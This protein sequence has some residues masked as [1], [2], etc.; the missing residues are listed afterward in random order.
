MVVLP[1]VDQ[2]DDQPHST[3]RLFELSSPYIYFFSKMDEKIQHG[4][5]ADNPSRSEVGDS[6]EMGMISTLESANE[7]KLIRK[8]DLRCVLPQS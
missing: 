6:N 7:K 5:H 4:V 8:I 2:T 1:I 3:L